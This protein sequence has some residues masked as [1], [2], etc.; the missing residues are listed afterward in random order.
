MNGLDFFILKEFV[1]LAK[2]LKIKRAKTKDPCPVCD[3]NLFFDNVQT[4]RIGILDD[5]DFVGWMCPFCKSQFTEDDK[6]IKI[7]TDV[8]ER[9][10]C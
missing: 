4:K 2:K 10:E 7:F 8:D 9:G 3:E 1:D 6:L 5:G